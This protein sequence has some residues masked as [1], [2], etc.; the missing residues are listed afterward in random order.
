MNGNISNTQ[1]SLIRVKKWCRVFSIILKTIL[2][3]FFLAIIVLLALMLFSALSNDSSISPIT[4]DV[5]LLDIVRILIL[6]TMIATTLITGSKILTDAAKGHSPFAQTQVKRIRII[7]FALFVYAILDALV[8]PGFISLFQSDTMS[9]GVQSL[10][11]SENVIIPINL[12]ALSAAGGF[13][14]LSLVFEY[15]VLLQQLS[16]ETL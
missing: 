1:T 15:G 16:D 10:P 9:I 11:D 8:S 3:L 6:Y 4:S 13:F 12:G 14:C 7:A 2:I 5:A